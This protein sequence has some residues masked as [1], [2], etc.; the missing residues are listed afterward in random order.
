MRDI[1]I[2]KYQPKD[3]NQVK[4]V[5]L[6]VMQDLRPGYSLESEERN[7][8]LEDIPKYY[9]RKGNFWVVEDNDR[10]VGTVGILDDHG[11][12]V[13]LKRLFLLSSY[14]MKGIGRKLLKIALDHCK[15]E[16]IKQIRAITST[17]VEIAENMLVKTGFILY[18][19]DGDLLFYRKDFV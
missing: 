1:I 17:H 9:S 7:K 6:S 3:K 12:F 14:R 13:W 5:V 10:I 11:D 2:R 8:D 15:K 19:Q 16:H 4:K 18:K